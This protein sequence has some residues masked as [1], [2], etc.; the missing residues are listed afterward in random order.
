[1]TGP[2]NLE[3]AGAVADAAV[4]DEAFATWRET[5]AQADAWLDGLPEHG[6]L[7]REPMHPDD[8]SR[9]TISD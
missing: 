1:M 7:D 4:V 2:G 3:F 8:G 6:A 9:P 5:A